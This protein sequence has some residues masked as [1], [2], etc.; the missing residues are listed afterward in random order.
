VNAESRATA[1]GSAAIQVDRLSRRTFL[2]SM[3]SL[4]VS[5]A[6]AA[7]PA[8][9]GGQ[10]RKPS[11]ASAAAMYRPNAWVTIGADDIVTVISPASEMGQG[12]K[13]SLP[14]LVAE[15]MDADWNKVRI[16]QAPAEGVR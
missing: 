8:G 13:T 6:F 1:S 16:L 10:S 2:A 9:M 11:A 5:V 15:E 12:V 3:G 14:L 7:E 4:V